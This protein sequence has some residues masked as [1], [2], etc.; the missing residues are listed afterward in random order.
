MDNKN[1]VSC[2]DCGRKL[3][4][5]LDTLTEFPVKVKILC[6]CGGSSFYIKRGY[7]V[8]FSPTAGLISDN[9]TF[10]ETKTPMV[11]TI[12]CKAVNKESK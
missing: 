6:P 5:V 8:I 11:M 2:G 10:D 3:G 1:L 9:V 7:K 4:F 12:E